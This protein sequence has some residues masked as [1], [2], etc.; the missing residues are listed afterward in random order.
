MNIETSKFT[1]K[2]IVIATIMVVI[3]EGVY[4]GVDLW[5]SW[6]E[7]NWGASLKAQQRVQA[8]E[9]T[10][11]ENADH[12]I[13]L[14]QPAFP[15]S[16]V[17]CYA[18]QADRIYADAWDG[19]GSTYMGWSELL[20]EHDEKLF[21]PQSVVV[22]KPSTT[23]IPFVLWVSQEKRPRALTNPDAKP[24]VS[25]LAIV[26]LDDVGGIECV[27]AAAGDQLIRQEEDAKR[28]SEKT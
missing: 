26:K 15:Q 20:K 27:I 2:G 28:I 11:Q 9:Q 5:K 1:M 19:N 21:T 17:R 6:M 10:A 18:A 13:H 25:G 23:I 7:V 14:S 3:G 4:F 16:S 22:L 12:T 8:V 24:V